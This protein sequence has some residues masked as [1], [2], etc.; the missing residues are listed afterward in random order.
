MHPSKIKRRGTRANSDYIYCVQEDAPHL[1]GE[2]A[3]YLN[4]NNHTYFIYE[5]HRCSENLR[6]MTEVCD[7][8]ICQPKDPPCAPENE[9]DEWL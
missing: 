9:I 1:L 3:D 5:I 6:N 4:G 7:D 2:Y 8:G